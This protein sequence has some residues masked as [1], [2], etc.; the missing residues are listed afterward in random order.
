MRVKTEAGWKYR[1]SSKPP[2]PGGLI[3]FKYVWGGGLE[4]GAYLITRG[5]RYTASSNNQK[6]ISILHKE[7]ERKVAKLKHM[8]LEVMQPKVK[9]KSELPTRV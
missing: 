8:K 3:Y 4:K 1:K 9:N 7:L 2:P 6:I 5:W